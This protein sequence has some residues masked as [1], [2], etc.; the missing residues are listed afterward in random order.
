MVS[1]IKHAVQG[2][3]IQ[4]RKQEQIANN[5]ANINTTGYKG[6]GLF[7]SSMERYLKNDKHQVDAVRELKADEVYTDYSEGSLRQTN[8]DLDFSLKGSG[9]F[10]VFT[11]EGMRYTRDGN[12][13][14]D[15]RGYLST[16]SG[17]RV[18]GQK[19][20]V[21]IEPEQGKVSVLE[22]GS[23]MQNGQEI[24]KMRISDFKKPYKLLRMGDNYFRPEL[25]NNPVVASQG[26]VVK[27]GYLE[28]SNINPIS[29]MTA[30]IASHKNYDVISK[31]IHS[32]DQTL[33]KTVSELAK[34]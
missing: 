30:M 14:L 34:I 18:M 13:S 28:T 7:A 12:F 25:P 23:I 26:Y 24:D 19:G 10:S 32:Q 2:M 16:S 8:N 22:D 9:F 15:D 20:F 1:G 31:A 21:R 27:Q 33:G 29:A 3:T 5:L 11:P 6:T 17:D 4:M